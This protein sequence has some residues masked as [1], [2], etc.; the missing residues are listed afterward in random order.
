[1]PFKWTIFFQASQ[2][3]AAK[4]VVSSNCVN[5]P[6]FLQVNVTVINPTNLTILVKANSL[7]T[8]QT[9]SLAVLGS[10]TGLLASAMNPAYR[11]GLPVPSCSQPVT[12]LTTKPPRYI[13]TTSTT[14]A[15]SAD[16]GKCFDAT[17]E[18]VGLCIPAIK[19]QVLASAWP[20]ANSPFQ[21]EE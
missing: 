12:T 1:M 7:F 6:S 17:F 19:A 21:S 11:P 2:V 14:F 8:G 13:N 18:D 20:V 3:E 16:Q 4:G 10:F 15:F 5:Q 9:Y